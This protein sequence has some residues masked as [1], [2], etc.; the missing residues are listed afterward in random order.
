MGP[1]LE[2]EYTL[3]EALGS[4]TYAQ[5]FRCTHKTGTDYAVKIVS[6]A[7]AGQSGITS[8]QSEVAILRTLDHPNIIRVQD[9]FD[10]QSS[11]YIVLEL[12]LG[13]ELFDKIVQ[14]K[15]YTEGMTSLLVR[16]LASTLAYLHSHNI[17]HR[18][19]K[20]ENL[21]LKKQAART[22][23]G[24]DIEF[25]ELLTSIKLVDFGFAT[26]F[27]P[28]KRE[29]TECCGTPNFI[30][31]EILQRGFF[32]TTKTGYSEACDIWS[33]GVLCY[34]LL[35]GYPPFHAGSRNQMFK[36]IC[37]G[38]ITFHQNTVWDK[39][40]QEAKQLIQAMCCLDVSKRLSAAEVLLHPWIQNTTAASELPEAQ[41]HLKDFGARRKMRGTIFGLAAAHRVSYL[42]QCT[43]LAIKPNSGLVKQLKECEDDELEVLDLTGNYLGAK[44]L[45]AAFGTISQSDTV[46]TLKLPNNQIDNTGVAVIVEGLKFHPSVTSV[47]LSH[48]PIT[49]LAGRQLL[50]LIQTNNLIKELKLE[51]TYVKDTLL[52]KINAQLQR[53]A[54]PNQCC[55]M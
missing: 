28:G 7:K 17:V 24:D 14:L 43:E 22:A 55:V 36:R 5:V 45:K 42:T 38:R 1:K 46:T 47:D 25:Q 29:L 44:G 9:T 3:S 30:A 2:D 53:N 23:E 49:Q 33:A 41:K 54:K 27:T 40:S 11:I 35:C 13:G 4:G 16:N 34:I 18:D 20:P 39:I 51:E 26:Q 52:Q 10:T 48:N 15:H 50:T 37:E 21:L 31:P 6:K 19:L 8:T 32:K 12:V